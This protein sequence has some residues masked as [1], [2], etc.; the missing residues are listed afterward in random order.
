M[1]KASGDFREKAAHELRES[2]SGGAKLA[3]SANLKRA[4]SYKALAENDAWLR[5]QPPRSR[6]EKIPGA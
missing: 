5:G 1:S 6:R 3:R 4:A 2:R